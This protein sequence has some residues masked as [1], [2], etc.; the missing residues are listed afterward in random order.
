MLGWLLF[1]HGLNLF[2]VIGREARIHTHSFINHVWCTLLFTFFYMVNCYLIIFFFFLTQSLFEN[3]AS[4]KYQRECTNVKALGLLLPH[5]L[6]TRTTLQDWFTRCEN[7]SA[8][9]SLIRF[10]ITSQK[11]KFYFIFFFCDGESAVATLRM[12]IR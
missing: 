2:L 10:E 4:M 7:G 5:G 11:I 9:I 1:V 3:N 6:L 12:H 8:A